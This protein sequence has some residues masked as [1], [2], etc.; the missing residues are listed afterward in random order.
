MI[1]KTKKIS[2]KEMMRHKPLD[3][4]E[5]MACRKCGTPTRIEPIKNPNHMCEECQRKFED[6]LSED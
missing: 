2:Y 1:K 4:Y 5:S 6:S 3:E